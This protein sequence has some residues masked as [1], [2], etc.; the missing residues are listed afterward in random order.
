MTALIHI[1]KLPAAFE[2]PYTLSFSNSG[3]KMKALSFCILAAGIAL[4]FYSLNYL[5]LPINLA[6]NRFFLLYPQ[7]SCIFYSDPGSLGVNLIF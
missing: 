4:I 5:T 1:L 3:F 6:F 7:K 2:A